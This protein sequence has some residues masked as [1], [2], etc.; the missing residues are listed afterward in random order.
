MT[1]K[2]PKG[3]ILRDGYTT[4]K[5]TKVPST[6]VKDMGK[7]GKGK[8]LFELKDAGMLGDFGYEL[9]IAHE[10]RIIAIKKSIKK[11]GANAVLKHLVAIRTLQKSNEKYF[12]KLDKDVKWIQ[13]NYF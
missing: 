10:K 11:N 1:K 4:K 5:G 2:C 7:P 12:N 13:K 8:K 9:K 3:E 6:C